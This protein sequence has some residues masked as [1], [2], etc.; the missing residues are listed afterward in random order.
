MCLPAQEHATIFGSALQDMQLA[1]YSAQMNRKRS[2]NFHVREYLRKAAVF[3]LAEW[4]DIPNRKGAFHRF[5]M[6]KMLHTRCVILLQQYF[7]ANS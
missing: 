5:E 7:F 1:V 2:R 4:F 6:K 3:H